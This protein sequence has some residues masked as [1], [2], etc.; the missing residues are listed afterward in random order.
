MSHASSA[1]SHALAPS[2][3]AST[4]AQPC[5]RGRAWRCPA[6]S[7]RSER[8]RRRCES[9][10]AIPSRPVRRSPPGDIVLLR[11]NSERRKIF[12]R[13]AAEQVG[14]NA[15]NHGVAGEIRHRVS[16]CRKFPVQHGDAARFDG[17][18]QQV[19]E[20][21]VA[22]DPRP[23]PPLSAGGGCVDKPARS[24]ASPIA[25]SLQYPQARFNDFV[26]R[27]TCRA[28]IVAGA[29]EFAQPDRGGIDGVQCRDGEHSSTSTIEARSAAQRPF[30]AI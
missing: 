30:P 23:T 11:R 1:S 22:M 2:S 28:H 7:P 12:A 29:A 3:T 19:V 26:Q 8:C 20:P 16:Q 5:R 24:D 13:Q 27:A 10:S 4:A 21:V 17:M 6:L 9:R 15:P 18:Q 14:R 25:D